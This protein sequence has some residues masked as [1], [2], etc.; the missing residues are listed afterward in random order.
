[1]RQ[2]SLPS[3]SIEP[4]THC[5]RCKCFPCFVAGIS[6]LSCP[7]AFLNDDE[8][9]I[10]DNI[11][12]AFEAWIQQDAMVMSWI[13][14]SVHAPLFWPPSLAKQALDQSGLMTWVG[15]FDSEFKSM[16]RHYCWD[17]SQKRMPPAKCRNK[18]VEQ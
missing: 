11:N 2:T 5:G 10:T 9:N 16:A 7:P 12:P 8:G 13:N 18:D 4:I 6:S 15:V 1:M 17:R 3:S 14:S